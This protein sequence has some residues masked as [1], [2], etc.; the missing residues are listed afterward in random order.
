MRQ[1]TLGSNHH[2]RNAI[3]WD[4]V[5]ADYADTTKVNTW[6]QFNNRGNADHP[7]LNRPREREHVEAILKVVMLREWWVFAPSQKTV[8]LAVAAVRLY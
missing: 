8:T 4:Q 2:C 5:R 1:P 6:D 3:D 7:G